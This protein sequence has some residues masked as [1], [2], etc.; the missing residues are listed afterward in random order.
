MSVFKISLVMSLCKDEELNPCDEG[1]GSQ[2]FKYVDRFTVDLTCAGTLLKV[3]V[4]Y[5]LLSPENPPD[6]MP[7]E[8]SLWEMGLDYEELMGLWHAGDVR[9]VHT[10][11]MRI[12][13]AYSDQCIREVEES[14]EFINPSI[15]F[16]YDVIK[17][18]P[19]FEAK[20]LNKDFGAETL[21][22]SI[23]FE[24][25]TRNEACTKPIALN[26][27]GFA[28][29]TFSAELEYPRWMTNMHGYTVARIFKSESPNPVW[30]I[31]HLP[32][33]IDY[34]RQFLTQKVRFTMHGRE[35]KQA[36]LQSLCDGSVGL[37]LEVDTTDFSKLLLH[38][39]MPGK[40]SSDVIQVVIRLSENF[41]QQPPS[42]KL[43]NQK[44]LTPSGGLKEKIIAFH[45]KAWNP[46]LDTTQLSLLFRQTLFPE[47]EA[48]AAVMYKNE[49]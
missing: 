32:K 39:E 48:F 37:P 6:F 1:N 40:N 25:S 38:Y 12:K 10:M 41:P 35:L 18:H 20:I 28:N 47:L 45:S 19:C 33:F 7:L 4:I 16:M 21:F 22:A 46:E 31:S 43:R 2:S 5:D 15:A 11:L 29:K 24:F 26:M 17:V 36:F 8:Q 27:K 13:R 30:D 42:Y 34:V 3:R 23:P 14:R 49:D 44:M 9:S